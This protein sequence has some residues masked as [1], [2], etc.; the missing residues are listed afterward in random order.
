MRNEKTGDILDIVTRKMEVAEIIPYRVTDDGRL[1]IMLH[2]GL[3]RGIVNAVPRAGINLDGRQWSG[4]MVEPLS[5][6][7]DHLREI[8]IFTPTK[9]RKFARDFLG[10]KP[11]AGAQI[12]AGAEYYPDPNYIDERVHTFYLE[13]EELSAPLPPK[14]KIFHNKQFRAKS[15]IRWNWSAGSC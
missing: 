3:I 2:D 14:D 10:M 9:T 1:I 13:V 7:Y 6:L 12:T 5:T 8:G 4:H 11:K 15:R